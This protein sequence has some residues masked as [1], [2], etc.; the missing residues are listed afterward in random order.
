MRNPHFFETDSRP[1]KI[2]SMYSPKILPL[3]SLQ[4][5]LQMAKIW[6]T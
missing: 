5:P 3:T 1:L 2:P 4:C 6:C